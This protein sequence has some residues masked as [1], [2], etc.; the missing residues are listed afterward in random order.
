MATRRIPPAIS[1][2]REYRCSQPGRPGVGDLNVEHPPLRALER[3]LNERGLADASPPAELDEEPAISPDDRAE[4]VE[5][6]TPSVE[7][8][9]EL[10]LNKFVSGR[11]Q[12]TFRSDT[13]TFSRRV[14]RSCSARPERRHVVA[15]PA[16]GA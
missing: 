1:M 13:Y 15:H 11:K 8:P 16:R 2:R 4:L 12:I 9:W 3:V 10:F 6:E 5:L 7:A 14:L